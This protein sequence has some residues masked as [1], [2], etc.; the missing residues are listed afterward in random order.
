MPD[1]HDI[2]ANILLIAKLQFYNFEFELYLL[3]MNL[4]NYYI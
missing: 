4:F 3:S 2:I 1:R